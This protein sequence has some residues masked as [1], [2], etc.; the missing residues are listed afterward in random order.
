MDSVVDSLTYKLLIIDTTFRSFILPKVPKMTPK[1][2]QICGCEIC[3]I[4]KD[5]Q[6]YLNILITILVIYLQKNFVGIHIRN[7]LFSY[8]IA[9]HYKE[10]FFPYGEFLNDTIKDADHCIT[11]IP[12][13]PKNVIHIKFSLGFC[14]KFPE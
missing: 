5:M 13:K 6:I 2:C 14:D 3:I 1:L 11:C 4:P 10:K 8:T 12:I 7:S 9:A